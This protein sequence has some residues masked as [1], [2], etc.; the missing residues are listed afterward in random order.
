MVDVKN[1]Q[2][3]LGSLLVNEGPSINIASSMF[4]RN[5]PLR[6][7]NVAK[8]RIWRMSQ[9][10][11]SAKCRK[12]GWLRNYQRGG[13]L[14]K[15]EVNFERG[16]RPPRKLCFEACHSA[17]SQVFGNQNLLMDWY[18]LV[19]FLQYNGIMCILWECLICAKYLYKLGK[20]YFRHFV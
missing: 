11:A 15:G 9:N 17:I 3:S 10:I 14:R 5:I 12:I 19:I 6:L 4:E 1:I 13:N 20:F 2:L 18:K 16:Y 7:Q 8:Y